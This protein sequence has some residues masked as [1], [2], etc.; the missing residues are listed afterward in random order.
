MQHMLITHAV[1]CDV[2]GVG[3]VKKQQ[4][5]VVIII[6]IIEILLHINIKKKDGIK[7]V[8]RI[9]LLQNNN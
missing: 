7:K 3:F 5:V 2:S 8:Q 9:L 6:V 1:G 4:H